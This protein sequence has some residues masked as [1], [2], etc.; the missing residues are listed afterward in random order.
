MKEIMKWALTFL[1]I[2]MG[3][4]G[5]TIH[6]I[7]IKSADPMVGFLFGVICLGLS[8]FIGDKILNK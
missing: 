3:I 1:P 6:S 4:G 8:L 2:T 5:F 7:R